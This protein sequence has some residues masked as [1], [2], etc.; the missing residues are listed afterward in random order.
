M[1]QKQQN[2]EGAVKK[3]AYSHNKCTKHTPAKTYDAGVLIGFLKGTAEATAA[4]CSQPEWRVCSGLSQRV[5]TFLRSTF[6][7]GEHK[8]ICSECSTHSTLGR[9]VGCVEVVA[10][11][12]KPQVL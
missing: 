9:E 2:C 6:V 7:G 8:I 4:L 1:P 12:P 10:P 11:P 5:N 3:L